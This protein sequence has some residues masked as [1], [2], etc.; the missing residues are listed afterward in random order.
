MSQ[1]QLLPSRTR[2]ERALIV[3]KTIAWFFLFVLIEL[4]VIWAIDPELSSYFSV[5]GEDGIAFIAN[6][7]PFLFEKHSTL[8]WFLELIN[9]AD[10]LF[11][12]LYTVAVT[13]LFSLLSYRK[14]PADFSKRLHASIGF[15]IKY[16]IMLFG[17]IL[18]FKLIV[19][20]IGNIENILLRPGALSKMGHLIPLMFWRL[21]TAY[22]TLGLGFTYCLIYAYYSYPLPERK[23]EWGLL[24]PTILWL[25][26][27]GALFILNSS[28]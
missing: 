12:L 17:F 27:S 23:M 28:S 3:G 22:F 11:L 18:L 21:E 26:I 14:R 5:T 25:L 8:G 20:S 4:S 15:S 7:L 13:I 24:I 10:F 2:K 19:F 6:A 9:I 1:E 16:T